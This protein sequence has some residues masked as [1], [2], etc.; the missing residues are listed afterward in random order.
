MAVGTSISVEE[1]LRTA[2]R[3]DRDYVDGE[4]VE[5]NL[6]EQSHGRLQGSILRWLWDRERE[7]GFRTL[8]EVRLQV[9]PNRFRIPDLMLIPP[10]ASKEKIIRTPPLLCI[11]VLSP[12]DTLSRIHR[13]VQ[14]YLNMGVP[15]CWIVDPESGEAWIAASGQLTKVTD[16]ILRA[17]DIEM[18]LAEVLE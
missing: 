6:G 2:Y 3:P 17:G 15:T 10:E 4:V 7:F 9:L 12:E 18:P 13:R 1:Y 8:P 16:G 11:E 5:R 14:E